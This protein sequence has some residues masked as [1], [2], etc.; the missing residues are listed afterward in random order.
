MDCSLPGSPVH[1]ILQVRPLRWVAH[2]FHS[3][4]GSNPH[5]LHCSWTLQLSHQGSPRD[6]NATSQNSKNIKVRPSYGRT[7]S[8][9]P[10]SSVD[11]LNIQDHQKEMFYLIMIC[12]SLTIR[13]WT[14]LPVCFGHLYISG[15]MSIQS[16]YHFLIR[17]RFCWVVWI[18]YIFWILFTPYQ[19]YDLWLFSLIPEVSFSICW[20]FSLLYRI[21]F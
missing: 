3:T 13:C 18:L 14:S 8:P 17:L 10:N 6:I 11:A 1:G 21:F 9:A 15:Q 5:H 12:I 7:V 16:L 19:N 2:P 4:Q 20:W